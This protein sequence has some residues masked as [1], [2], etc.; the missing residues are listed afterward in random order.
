MS[1]TIIT[2]GTGFIGSSLARRLEAERGP[3]E[4]VVAVSSRTVD[5]SNWSATAAWFE[6]A[7]AEH[8]VRVIFHLAALYK[9]G[10]W[11]TD[12]PAT[13]LFANTS[14]N[15]NVLEAWKRFAP[16]AKLTSVM[17]YCMY[18]P[19]DEPHPES[20]LWGTEPEPRSEEHTSEL[21]SH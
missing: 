7:C 13:Q 8:D 15:M 11:P 18:P 5:L 20:E 1:C 16:A 12:H 21:Q 10:G 6:R 2:G 4:R 14:I 3:G 19:H 17:S 9:A